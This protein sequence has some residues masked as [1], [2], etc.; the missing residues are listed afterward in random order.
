MI[1]CITID[2]GY[3]HAT[4][5]PDSSTCSGYVAVAASDNVMQG[6]TYPEANQLIGAVGLLFVLAFIFRAL[7]KQIGF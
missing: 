5:M 1:A 3:T 4:E 6:L 2:N 7:R